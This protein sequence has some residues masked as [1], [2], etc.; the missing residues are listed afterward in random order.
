M[1]GTRA[2]LRAYAEV[3][4]QLPAVGSLPHGTLG[5]EYKLSG[6]RNK[7]FFLQSHLS[8]V[9]FTVRLSASGLVKCC[10]LESRSGSVCLE[11]LDLQKVF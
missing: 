7:L 11:N 9:T 4:G 1:M 6:L 3:R 10:G 8:A 5:I 2:Y